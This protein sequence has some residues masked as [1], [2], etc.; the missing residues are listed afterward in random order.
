[1]AERLRI[2][3]AG[4]VQGVGFRPFV[5]RLAVDLGVQGWVSS[6]PQGVI[7][8]AEASYET[9]RLF[10]MRITQERPPL[11]RIQRLDSSRLEAVGYSGFEIRHDQQ[12]KGHTSALILPDIATCP[13]CLREI[14][15]PHNRRYRY[16]FT[17]CTH[18]GSRFSIIDRL[19]YDRSNTSLK[20]FVMC[21][22]CRAEYDNPR[23]RRFHA[24]PNACPRCGPQL[25]LWN[26]Q[27]K[28][29][30]TCDEALRAAEAALKRGKIV[31]L[32]ALGGFYLVVDAR[33]SDAVLRLRV[34]KGRETKPFPVMLPSL[35]MAK[36][37]CQVSD[38]EARLLSAP[39]APIVI[40]RRLDEDVTDTAP[41]A[42]DEE[43]FCDVAAEVAPEN[44]YLGVMLPYS[45]LYH[46]LM[47]DLGFPLV[48][49]SGNRAGEPVCSDESAA[50]ARLG[51][52]ADVFL[53]NNRPIARQVD[54]SVVRIM[55]GREVMLR[56]ARGYAPF[57]IEL[58]KTAPCL[59]AAGAHLRNTVAV[60]EGR[61]VFLSQHIGDMET[62]QG[63]EAFQNVI[64]DFLRLYDLKPQVVIC[65]M[66]SDKHSRR[67][68]AA[69]HL[70]VTHVQHHYA[71]ILAC[72]AEHGMVAPALGVAWDGGAYGL[73][74][75]LWGGE[76]LL[77]NDTSFT[78][79]AQLHPFRLPGGPKAVAEPR[80]SAIGLLHEVYGSSIPDH[81]PPIASF[82]APEIQL[83]Y[84]MLRENITS[85][86]TTSAGRLFDAVAALLGVRYVNRFEGQAAQML[87][88]MAESIN[89]DECYSFEVTDI[90]S[91]T[92]TL[93]RIM[94]W[95]P[96][97]RDI[98]DDMRGGI[99]LN[100]IAAKFHNTLANM[101]VALAYN[102]G[103]KQVVLSGGCFQNKLLL[104]RAVQRLRDAGFRPYWSK[105]IPPN[106]GGIALGQIMAALRES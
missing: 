7:I 101:I 49:T 14:F 4:A 24:Q 62:P 23:D 66:P 38:Q 11:S 54:D 77:I 60:T 29:L 65:D 13:D 69:A 94:N 41:R 2:T 81:L 52:I 37:L 102:F 57:P 17:N 70:P 67:F 98:V 76:F 95:K 12:N 88:F 104:E 34:L 18:C 80:R 97:I 15:D 68:A 40:L 31:A 56:R 106:D 92:P 61:H 43:N 96:M 10:M 64:D 84:T 71:H 42:H 83:L 22:E 86:T 30:E 48:M 99:S 45:P 63:Y 19:P 5:Y 103:E 100:H 26:A 91:E 33:D 27:G 72:M 90:T 58:A 55:A 85:P 51:G 25:S 35:A 79:V 87:E 16:A 1:M 73:D 47:N 53:I 105:R 9:L 39:E 44:P 93:G 82:S 21:D 59:L 50:L 36:H 74:Q 6:S 46:L 3:I 28:V 20:N 32:K 78:R 75:T 89:T 8:E